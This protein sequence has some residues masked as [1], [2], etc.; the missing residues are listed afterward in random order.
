MADAKMK[1]S[2][3]GAVLAMDDDDLINVVTYNDQSQTYVSGK[4]TGAKVK[5]YMVGDN[6]ISA[7]GDGSVTGAILN[8]KSTSET[9]DSNIAE[10]MAQNGAHNLCPLL[11]SLATHIDSGLTITRNSDD[12]IGLSGTYGGADDLWLLISEFYATS[13]ITFKCSS[14]YPTT[15]ANTLKVCFSNVTTSTDAYDNDGGTNEVTLAASKG[16][17]ICVY[18]IVK[19]NMAISPQALIQPMMKRA[20][21]PSTEYAPYAMTNKELTAEVVNVTKNYLVSIPSS[22]SDIKDAALAVYNAVSQYLKYNGMSVMVDLEWAGSDLMPCMVT[23]LTDTYCKMSIF[24]QSHIYLITLTNGAVV[25]AYDY[26]GTI[27]N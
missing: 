17:H 10:T 5:E 19:K 11:D 23:R 27:I 3:M 1:V 26:N 15:L 13:D 25:S 4:A 7:L 8:V 16:D 2:Q 12:T 14:K 21:D 6:D 18:I 22:T 20:S 24:N 9:A